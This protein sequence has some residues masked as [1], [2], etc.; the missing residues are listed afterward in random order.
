[1][2]RVTKCLRVP[3]NLGGEEEKEFIVGQ[4][5][6]RF[7]K[8]GGKGE[9]GGKLSPF[10]FPFYGSFS[11][12]FLWLIPPG[13]PLNDF[14]PWAWG[15]FES[16]VCACLMSLWKERLHPGVDWKG[17][18]GITI[19]EPLG[20]SSRFGILVLLYLIMNRGICTRPPSYLKNQELKERLLIW[21]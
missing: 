17:E 15:D 4:N 5:D 10:S 9:K 21:L 2:I 3:S 12:R 13:N 1:M 16:H 18:G 7:S 8:A 20:I 6:V 11:S 19:H 14:S